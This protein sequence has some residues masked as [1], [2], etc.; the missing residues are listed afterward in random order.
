[1]VKT[2][3]KRR[4]TR[5][6]RRLYELLFAAYGPQEWWPADTPFEVVIGT[7]LVQNTSW[8]SVEH[9][10]ANLHAK[11]L[12]TPAGIRK[13]TEENLRLLIRPSG[14]M[15]RKAKALKGF[16]AFLDREYKGSMNCLAEESTA[17]ARTKLLSLYGVGP[18]TAD[19]ILL[20]ALGHPVMVVDEYFRRVAVRHR[21]CEDRPGYA[22]LQNLALQAF[23][24]D[25]P[26][27][28]LKHF[29]EFHALIVEVGK[30]HCCREPKCEACPLASDLRRSPSKIRE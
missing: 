24:K 17:V 15:Q 3:I 10:I 22:T 8:S 13:T 5:D 25:L 21:F 4:S 12:L 27:T 11:E 29:N 30:R 16:V 19:A 1:M 7:Y 6:L 18:E 23:A 26:I 14:Y 2:L 9:S 20:Y 28:H